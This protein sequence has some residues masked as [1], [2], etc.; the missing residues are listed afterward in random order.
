MMAELVAELSESLK[1]DR[2]TG[3]EGWAA[4][5]CTRPNRARLTV[6]MDL[7]EKW[8]NYC[9]F[10]LDGWRRDSCRPRRRPLPNSASPS[11]GSTTDLKL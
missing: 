3:K 7:G 11:G 10:A 2:K 4:G 5:R 1:R 9:I 8:S 6:G